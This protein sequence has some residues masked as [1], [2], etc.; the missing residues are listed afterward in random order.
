MCAD[1][2]VSSA[3]KHKLKR[4]N[5]AIPPASDVFC[6]IIIAVPLDLTVMTLNHTATIISMDTIIKAVPLHARKAIGCRGGIT[7]THSRPR[8]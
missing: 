6:H 1:H 2:Y 8:H 7:P 3:L 4:P 5:G